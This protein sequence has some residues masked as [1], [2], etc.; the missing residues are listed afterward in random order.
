[1]P[2]FRVP[3]GFTMEGCPLFIDRPAGKEP[4]YS[5]LHVQY[6]TSTSIIYHMRLYNHHNVANPI[7]NLQLAIVCASNFWQNVGWVKPAPHGVATFEPSDTTGLQQCQT[8]LS[9]G[10]PQG[11]FLFDAG[12][13]MTGFPRMPNSEEQ[14]KRRT[15][16]VHIWLVVST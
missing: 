10:L 14:K 8:P 9:Q 16:G 5:I 15:Y 7:T 12:L 11:L 1:M 6:H 4:L 3:S 2:S 13:G